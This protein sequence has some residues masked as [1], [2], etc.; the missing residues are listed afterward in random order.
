[1][2]TIQGGKKL[3]Q[4]YNSFELKQKLQKQLYHLTVNRRAKNNMVL[5]II[6]FLRQGKPENTLS[7]SYC[8]QS[9]QT[10]F[11]HLLTC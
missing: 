8:C 10:D 11:I 6:K 9:L 7:F 4:N 1:M 5:V 3:T 2:N